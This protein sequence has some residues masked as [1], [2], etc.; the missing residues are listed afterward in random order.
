[1]KRILLVLSVGFSVS[2]GAAPPPGNGPD[3]DSVLGGGKSYS[4]IFNVVA[5]SGPNG[6]AA[7]GH[8]KAQNVNGFATPFDI[9]AD[10]TCLR[11]DGDLATIGGRLTKLDNSV[12][13]TLDV[14]PGVI[15]YVKDGRAT[16]TAD[17]ISYQFP[18]TYI[19]TSCP[20]PSD[21][22]TVFPLLQG[23]INVHDE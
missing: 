14:Y 4:D 17:A 22:F 12:G 2:V 1:M 13:Y 7:F 18:V 5:H 15:Q 3:R 21:V 16:G 20:A 6:E 23:N 19:P 8:L 9:E 10:V 11:V